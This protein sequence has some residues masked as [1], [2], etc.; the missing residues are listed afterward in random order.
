MA[1]HTVT[2]LGLHSWVKDLWH[3]SYVS[4]LAVASASQL[5]WSRAKWIYNQANKAS[6]DKVKL[7]SL[8]VQGGSQWA[9]QL[10]DLADSLAHSINTSVP[11]WVAVGLILY[12]LIVTVIHSLSNRSVEIADQIMQCCSSIYS[13][14]ACIRISVSILALTGIGCELSEP[15]LK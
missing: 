9:Q 2:Q 8:H 6:T 13:F 14:S 7:E 12:S 5:Y 1:A 11:G 10:T 3:A 4:V 15:S